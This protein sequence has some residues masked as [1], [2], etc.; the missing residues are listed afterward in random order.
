MND[1]YQD[2][3]DLKSLKNEEKR[4]QAIV[5]IYMRSMEEWKVECFKKYI[6]NAAEVLAF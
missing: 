1:E 3:S 4:L 2:E 5:E 6:P